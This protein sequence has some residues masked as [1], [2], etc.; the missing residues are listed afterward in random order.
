VLAGV[1]DRR[2]AESRRMAKMKDQAMS[3][4]FGERPGRANPPA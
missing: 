3:L 2:M 1:L 4:V